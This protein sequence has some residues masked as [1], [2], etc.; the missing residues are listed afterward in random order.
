VVGA[1]LDRSLVA[2][3]LFAGVLGLAV[4]L[5][6]RAPASLFEEPVAPGS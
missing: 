2:A 5:F 4:A 6:A 1:L 3:L